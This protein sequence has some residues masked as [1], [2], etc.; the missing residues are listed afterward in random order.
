MTLRVALC[1]LHCRLSGISLNK[2]GFLGAISNYQQ[3]RTKKQNRAQYILQPDWFVNKKA[4]E[5]DEGLTSDNEAFVRQVIQ[6]SFVQQGVMKPDIENWPRQPYEKNTRRCG[7]LGVKIGVIPQWTKDGEKFY[8]TL[9]QLIDNHVIRYTQPEAY[10]RSGGWRPW[11]GQRFGSVVVGAMDCD[12]RQFSKDYTNLFRL[13]GVPPKKRLTRFLVTPNAAVEPG[14]PLS[15]MH[16]RVGDYVD[17]QGKT[18][19]HGFQGVI[20]RWGM[21]GMPKS[22]GVTKAH[23]K[24]G[25]TGAGRTKAAIWKGKKMPGHMGD[26]RSTLKGLKIW[27]INTQYNVLYVHGPCI[28]GHNHSVVRIYDTILPHKRPTANNHPPM[29]TW[30]KGDSPEAIPLEFLDEKLHNMGSGSITFKE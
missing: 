20:K 10:A 23:R 9:L 21:K 12:P 25:S 11:W 19:D 7:V 26:E 24:M 16:F 18:I 1:Q 17:V 27:R 3:I 8:C 28:P 15:V 22:H 13:A 2:F 6:E 29:P 5:Q 4:R 30:Y 14:T